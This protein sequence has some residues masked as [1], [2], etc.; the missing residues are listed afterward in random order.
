MKED[1]IFRFFR[2]K[3]KKSPEQFIYKINKRFRSWIIINS[4][5]D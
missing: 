2:E 4:F 5:K 3:F 1:G